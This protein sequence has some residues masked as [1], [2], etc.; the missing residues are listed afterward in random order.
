MATRAQLTADIQRTSC[1]ACLWASCTGTC[2]CAQHA[3]NPLA[4]LQCVQHRIGRSPKLSWP[5][6]SSNHHSVRF[7]CILAAGSML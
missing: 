1:S 3:E 2:S 5:L 6:Q 4:A 7:L